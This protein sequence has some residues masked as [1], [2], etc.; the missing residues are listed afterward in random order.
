MCKARGWLP[1]KFVSPGFSGVPDRIILQPGG[2]IV[3]VET[4][5]PGRAAR[6]RQARVHA[7]LRSYGFRV[8]I[9][10]KLLK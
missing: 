4:K 1:L 3:F 7:L 9:L 10:D 5:A 2:R 6:A 8:V